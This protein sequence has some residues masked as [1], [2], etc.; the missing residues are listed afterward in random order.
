MTSN[1]GHVHR[2]EHRVDPAIASEIEAV[3]DRFTA[4][5]TRR[6]CHR[7]DTAPPCELS[8]GAEPGWITGLDEEIIALTAAM[9]TS[10]GESI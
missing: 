8:F 10:L 2:V 3:M 1:L 9:P 7:R 5:L 4:A 6:R